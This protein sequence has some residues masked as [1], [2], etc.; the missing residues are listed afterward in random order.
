[1]TTVRSDHHI[2]VGKVTKA[3]LPKPLDA[4]PTSRSR[5]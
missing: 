5:K 1:M 4:V 2:V 3:Q